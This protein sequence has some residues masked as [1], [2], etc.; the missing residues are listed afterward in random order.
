M[1]FNDILVA[2]VTRL[3]WPQTRLGSCPL[4]TLLIKKHLSNLVKHSKVR[5]LKW[6]H[7]KNLIKN[8]LIM[9]KSITS[10]KHLTTLNPLQFSELEP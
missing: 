3:N 9:T 8:K 7:I 5:V 2:G 10:E 4:L 1:L 6:S